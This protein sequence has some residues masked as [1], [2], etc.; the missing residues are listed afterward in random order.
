VTYRIEVVARD[1]AGYESTPAVVHVT[2]TP[3]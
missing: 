2:V 3:P 1:D